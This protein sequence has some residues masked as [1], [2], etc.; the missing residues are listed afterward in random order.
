MEVIVL[1]VL[2][3]IGFVDKAETVYFA[4]DFDTAS[5]IALKA[6]KDLD[7]LPNS[8][9]G[10][11]MLIA[12]QHILCNTYNRQNKCGKSHVTKL[13][14]LSSHVTKLQALSLHVCF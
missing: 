12:A 7:S 14:T 10:Y 11:Y 4:Q 6:I 1:S 5:D 13:D 3:S 9:E 2:I 8:E